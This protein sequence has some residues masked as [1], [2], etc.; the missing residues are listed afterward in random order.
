MFGRI[1][2]DCI[3]FT[4]IGQF[5]DAASLRGRRLDELEGLN[6]DLFVTLSSPARRKTLAL[7]RAAQR[8]NGPYPRALR[9]SARR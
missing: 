1:R 8:F 9:G 6:F 2:R 3:R 4:A 7:K 5:R